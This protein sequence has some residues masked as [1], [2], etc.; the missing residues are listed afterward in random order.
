[1]SSTAKRTTEDEETGSFS[2]AH[3]HAQHGNSSRPRAVGPTVMG[4]PTVL[5]S[6]VCYC[7]A[8]GS[9]VLLNKHALNPKAR[10]TTR[11]RAAP[12]KHRA[13]THTRSASSARDWEAAGKL[14]GRDGAQGG[15]Q[16]HPAHAC[17]RPADGAAGLRNPSPPA[18]PKP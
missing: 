12:P 17:R 4:I 9:M 11:A 1:M 15:P 3:Q 16:L 2:K 6:G 10:S 8:S 18:P 7:V 14:A 13:P 5:F